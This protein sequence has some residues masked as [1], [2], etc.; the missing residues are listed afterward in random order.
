MAKASPFITTVKR[1]SL[2]H[3]ALLA[4]LLYYTFQL[5][6]G[7][8][9]E[10]GQILTSDSKAYYAYLP[11]IIIHNDAS[12]AY[13]R[14][15]PKDQADKIWMSFTSDGH[16][17]IKMSSG[18]AMC[19]L[20]AFLVAHAY[21]LTSNDF[22]ATGYETPYY[23][24]ILLN[25]VLFGMWG[26]WLVRSVLLRWFSEP[27]VAVALLLLVFGTNLSFYVTWHGGYSHVYSFWAIAVFVYLTLRWFDGPTWRTTLWIGIAT[28]IM[29]LIR[30]TNALGILFFPLWGIV[31][32]KSIKTQAALFRQHYLKLLAMAFLGLLIFSMQILYWKWSVDRWWFYGYGDEGFYWSNPHLSEVLFSFRKGWLLYTPA[33]VLAIVG[34]FC[35]PSKLRKGKWAVPLLIVAHIYIVS[36]WY[37]WWFGDS[38]SQ[39]SLV[40]FYPLMAIPTAALLSVLFTRKL[41]IVGAIAGVFI[42]GCIFLNLFQTQQYKYGLIHWDGMTKEA[43]ASIW[44]QK[45]FPLGYNELIVR[46]DIQRALKGKE[47]YI[48]SIASFKETGILTNPINQVADTDNNFTEVYT[49]PLHGLATGEKRMRAQCSVNLEINELV[50]QEQFTYW[51]TVMTKDRPASYRTDAWAGE[52]RTDSMSTLTRTIDLWPPFAPTDSVKICVEWRFGAPVKVQDFTIRVLEAPYPE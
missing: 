11:N 29:V 37:S 1:L 23:L 25:A 3:I 27:A 36:C 40:D 5:T 43:Y 9:Y 2:S 12:F 18:V 38:Y 30:P 32:W 20:P 8:R 26:L 49:L 6:T 16:P 48:S 50:H 35:I 28:G 39:R 15:L 17:Y 4:I 51:V 42:V 45:Q 47:E 10:N 14:E 41:R 21:A 44:M 7:K 13:A 19:Q 24:A 33:M 22:K 34:L 52:L 46:P 31:N